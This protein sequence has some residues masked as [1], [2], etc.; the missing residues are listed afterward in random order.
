MFIKAVILFKAV[1]Y[2]LLLFSTTPVNAQQ[3]TLIRGD[4]PVFLVVPHGGS[5]SLDNA[6]ERV[7]EEST[8]PH[9]SIKKDL[10][11]SEL[12]QAIRDR[13]PPGQRPSL[14]LSEVHRKYVDL[15][16]PPE[17]ATQ[18]QA[19][20]LF[21]QHFHDTLR[22]ELE[23]LRAS[24]GWVLLID[25]HGQSAEKV[26]LIVGTREGRTV[27]RWS[28]A[29]LWGKGGL[30]S[31]LEKA[32]FSTAPSTVHERVRYNGGYIVKHY[33]K[34]EWVEA[35]QLEHGADLRFEQ[36]RTLQYSRILSEVLA[37]ST[38]RPPTS[39]RP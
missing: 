12:A 35:W 9:F 26:D 13:F 29:L 34:P 38:R 7:E 5:L 33:G 21:H 16:R 23:R 11:T 14:L 22:R 37:A 15:N 31:K 20:R 25:V 28:E 36:H 39:P 18:S 1:L 17:H 6:S 32:G 4:S 19:G 2:S 3:L 8:D 10:E 30:L 27:S 24:H